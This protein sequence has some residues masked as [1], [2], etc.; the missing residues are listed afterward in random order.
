MR[1]LVIGTFGLA[2]VALLGLTAL[3]ADEGKEEKVALDKLPKAVTD[4]V[5][6]KFEGCKLVSA[7]KEKEDGKD[8]FEVTIK[9]KGHTI[10]VTLTPEGT[11]VSIE[12]EIEAKDLPKAV[13]E[14]IDAKYP[15]ATIKKAE[16]VTKGD[17]VSYEALIVTADK[18]TLEVVFDPKGKFLEEEK[19]DE[20]KEE[21]KDK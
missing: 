21:K 12:K 3:R 11:L 15:K 6:A 5:K 13:S 4:A 8:V 18:K 1:T 19:K 17:K 7:E 10:E 9:H 2:L 14:A 16:E 20:K